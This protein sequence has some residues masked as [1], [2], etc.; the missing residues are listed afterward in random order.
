M[1][2]STDEAGSVL[3]LYFPHGYLYIAQ[4]LVSSGCVSHILD[5]LQYLFVLG[6]LEQFHS[7]LEYEVTFCQIMSCI[8]LVCLVRCHGVSCA[9][10]CRTLYYFVAL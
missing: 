7:A 10:T 2:E 1:K 8:N 6:D 3:G 4:L 5:K 9:S